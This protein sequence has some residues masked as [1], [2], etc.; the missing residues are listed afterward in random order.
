MVFHI[1][2][3]FFLPKWKNCKDPIIAYGVLPEQETLN[4]CPFNSLGCLGRGF[5]RLRQVRLF[6]EGRYSLANKF[7][8][9]F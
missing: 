4:S 3:F 1:I 6:Y 5:Y 7:L 2:V 8:N 9:I